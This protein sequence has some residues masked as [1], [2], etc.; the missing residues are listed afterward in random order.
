M[1]A[2]YPISVKNKFMC[3]FIICLNLLT[4]S[5]IIAHSDPSTGYES[6]IYDSTTNILWISLIFSI[7]C[8][9]LIVL[10]YAY[11]E[12]LKQ[13]LWKIGLFIIYL[14]YIIVL[15][16][17]IIRGYFMWCMS[18]DPASHLGNVNQIISTGYVPT[19][20]FYPILH[21]YTSQLFLVLNI[22]IITLH[23]ILPLIFGVLYPPFFYTL[24][25]AVFSEKNQI[26][27]STIAS[28][29]FI[30]G[31]YLNLTPNGLSNLYFPLLLS[32]SLNAVYRK[33]VSWEML[34]V[35]MVFFYPVFHPVPTLVLIIIFSTLFLSNY[36]YNKRNIFYVNVNEKIILSRF[37][38]TL[39]FLLL[40]WSITWISSFYVWDST[41]KN[42]YILMNEGGPS[43]VFGLVEDINYAKGY[44]YNVFEQALK[45]IGGP[46]VYMI[47]SI[48]SFP[49]IYKSK[50][51]LNNKY[52]LDNLFSLYGPILFIS[53]FI[54]ILY[55]LNMEFDPLR[56]VTYVTV[57]STLFVGYFFNHLITT[58][59]NKHN[60]NVILPFVGFIFILLL[61]WIN[62]IL[63]LYPSPYTWE[64]NSQTTMSEI[65]GMNWLLENK[66]IDLDITGITVTPYRF[67]RLLL[68]PEQNRL[69]K[70]YWSQ[71]DYLRVPYHF[72]YDNNTEI[73][74]YYHKS[75]YLG[76]NEKD[77]LIYSDLFPE[78]A[79]IR[80]V[81]E[82]FEEL[83]WDR[84]TKKIYSSKKFEIFYI[85]GLGGV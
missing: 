17:F 25:K 16:L 23:K 84:S 37:K 76:I 8:G 71:P 64:T 13:G 73:S 52:N 11:N 58:L 47:I 35:I 21:V 43:N 3:I 53:L 39:I 22:D 57:I 66:N 50:K 44:G 26:I 18:G 27:L 59:K 34:I 2:R 15:S 42:I 32:I 63:T 5:L 33:K 85:D 45:I 61:V 24:S 67:G 20:L 4:I 82:D 41:I 28:N 31:W 77:K 19:H 69:Q 7:L 65:D 68:T 36:I 80:W 30:N 12:N 62:G 14:C 72:G 74:I 9:T 56:V 46:L 29:T 1:Y 10:F 49:F 78:M 6:S 48:I 40:V 54:I 55:F 38:I 83:N 70:F 79:E 75:L 51:T 60:T 81:P